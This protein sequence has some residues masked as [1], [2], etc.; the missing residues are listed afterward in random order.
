MSKGINIT[1]QKCSHDKSF[2][3]AICQL[4]QIVSKLEKGDIS[5][6]DS[7]SNFQEGIELSRY[8]AAKLDEAE[9]KISV[10]LQDEEGN[11]VEKD[12]EL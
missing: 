4:E 3:E 6:E 10:L 8:C 5:L 7:I 2:E 9:K 1:E 12:F 11:L